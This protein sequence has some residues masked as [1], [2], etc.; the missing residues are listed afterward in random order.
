MA[1]TTQDVPPQGPARP[2]NTVADWPLKF[3]QHNFGV[4]SYSTYGCIVDYNGFR[5]LSEPDDKLK[6]ALA[7][8]HP[9]ALRN[10]SVG[11]LGVMNFPVPA[12]VRWRSKDGVPHEATVD[13]GEIFK[14]QL[15]LHEVPRKDIREGVSIGNPD[16]LLV[17][18]N[19]TIQV[20]MRAFIPTKEP[21]IEGNPRSTHRDDW[22]L[23]WS[24]SY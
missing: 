12:H 17:V 5:H 4:R 20:Y 24:K 14:D 10:A 9:D 6:P 7:D 22:V 19:R 1:M 13:I 11:Y 3:V 2:D 15:I 18:D 8:V 16:V 21:Q 23:A